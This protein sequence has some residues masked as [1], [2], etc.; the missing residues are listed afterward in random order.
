MTNLIEQIQAGDI[1]LIGTLVSGSSYQHPRR[2]D[3]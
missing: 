1:S 3:K 2:L